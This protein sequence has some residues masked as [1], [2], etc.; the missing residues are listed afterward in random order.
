[1]E[2][3]Y[4]AFL[5][6]AQNTVQSQYAK[7][8]LRDI[9]IRNELSDA[10][11][12][13]D[14]LDLG[15]YIHFPVWT[16]SALFLLG[17]LLLIEFAKEYVKSQTIL[18][19]LRQMLIVTISLS[20]LFPIYEQL[21]TAEIYMQDIS[22]Y[23]GVLMPTIGTLCAA[24]G[25]LSAA[26]SLGTLLPFFLSAI[27]ILLQKI[28]P[29]VIA[30]FLGFSVME[31]FSGEKTMHTLSVTIRNSLFAFF[32]LGTTIFFIVISFQNLA[33]ANTDT[34]TA[35][36]FR[37]LLSNAVPI[38]GGSIGEALKLVG[39][40]LVSIKNT[41]G[42]TSVIF[43]LLLYLPCICTTWICRLFLQLLE[44]ICTFLD[45]GEVSG[46][47]VH[48]KCALDFCIACFTMIFVV[49]VVNIGIFIRTLPSLLT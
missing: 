23:L 31:T 34:V 37:V 8:L 40:G 10:I 28:F 41:I 45:F 49:G 46:I 42:T 21:S 22:L 33:A 5:Y 13:F 35:R 25:N 47:L 17:I 29:A 38:I 15:K 18:S 24:G 44:L 6:D 30:L 43:I 1:M 20:V 48:L 32:A 26:T 2:N 19:V 4:A 11:S 9:E 36:S 14:K 3:S 16:Q 27:Q 12:I 7:E 39:G